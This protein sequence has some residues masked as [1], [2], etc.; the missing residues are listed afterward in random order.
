M[1]QVSSPGLPPWPK[2]WLDQQLNR[3]MV[4]AKHA[5]WRSYEIAYR[6]TEWLLLSFQLMFVLIAWRLLATPNTPLRVVLVLI[7]WMVFAALISTFTRLVFPEPLARYIFATK[8]TLWV[9]DR[10]II[11]KS[12]LYRS[13]VVVWRSWKDKSVRLR[14]IIQSDPEA[15]NYLADQQYQRK[16]PRGPINEAAI[17]TLVIATPQ[18]KDS[19]QAVD[20]TALQRA[21]P[22]M[23]VSNRQAQKF[24]TAFDAALML[25][26]NEVQ[27]QTPE[28]YSRGIDI[29]AA[30]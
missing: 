12:R 20:Q 28:S 21:V 23:E 26:G 27:T 6:V 14:F 7:A 16:L 3:A 17:V 10:S 5:T 18:S 29:D 15:A 13:P 24:S 4:I 19:H 2:V 8:T 9:T 11:F 1:I 25:I 22:I 30:P